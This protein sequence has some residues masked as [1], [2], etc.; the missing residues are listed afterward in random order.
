[1]LETAVEYGLVASNAAAG[2]RRLK[3]ERPRRLWVE[4]EQLMS[5]LD[6]AERPGRLLGGR[7]R[8]LLATLAGAGLRIDEA[9]S[10]QRR[11]VNTARG[12]LTVVR[13]KTDAGIRVVDIPPG[14]RDELATYLDE[15][16]PQDQTAFVFGTSTGKKDNPSNV[17]NRLFANAIKS[18]NERLAALG[19]EQL[20]PV[21]PH[22]LRRTYAS[23]RMACG[24]DPVYVSRQLGHEDVPVHV[25]RVRAGGEAS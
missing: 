5:L 16:V 23:L 22:G 18:A 2:R 3:A 17:R 1:V 4:P 12:T 6:A 9:L 13:S 19:I 25:E 11:H 21:R 15:M 24:D 10:L 8:P 7:G 14:L 20:G